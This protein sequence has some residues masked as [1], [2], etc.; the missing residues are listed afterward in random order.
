[1]V[2]IPPISVNEVTTYY[3]YM[4]NISNTLF[5]GKVLLR[6]KSLES[7]NLEAQKLLSEANKPLEGTTIVAD[8]QTAGKGQRGNTWSS[9]SG[10][11]LL[12]SYILYP[13]HLLPRQQFVLNIIS[14]LAVIDLLQDMNIKQA[15]I[16]WPNDVYIGTKKV[17]GILTQSHIASQSILSSIIGIGLNVNQKTFDTTL[18]N[19]TSI[20]LEMKQD[21][22]LDS[23]L[24][25]LCFFLEKRYLQ[26]K[27]TNGVATLRKLYT[28]LLFRLEE[29]AI[30]LIDGKHQT[31]II[32]GIDPNGKLIL[33]MEKHTR[34]FDF[35]ELRF[36]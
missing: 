35:Q 1:M 13:K 20:R 19:P 34:V 6:Y 2:K 29:E 8:M 26:S 30:F 16:K 25:R 7:T 17:A 21:F 15:K 3:S 14:S 18:P 10:K 22:A 28:K 32:Q 27:S 36:V 4:S 5:I 11:N 23:T 9:P 31:G 33:K 24:E 12:S